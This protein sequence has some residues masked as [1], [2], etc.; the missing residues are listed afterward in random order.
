M[1]TM[2]TIVQLAMNNGM[3]IVITVYFLIRDWK[4][5]ATLTNL[6]GTLNSA[7]DRFNATIDTMAQEALKHD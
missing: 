7:V 6:L 3:A 1:E 5:Q 4:Y 2:E